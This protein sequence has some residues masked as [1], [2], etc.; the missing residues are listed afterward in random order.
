[1]ESG[2]TNLYPC[3]LFK[4]VFDFWWHILAVRHRVVVD[5]FRVCTVRTISFV[6]VFV[7]CIIGNAAVGGG[8][9]GDGD[10]D[11]DGSAIF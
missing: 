11:G 5:T 3:C 7:I 4:V 2:V 1:M 6:S 9:D 10:G 8:G